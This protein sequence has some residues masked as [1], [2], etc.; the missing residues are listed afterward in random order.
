MPAIET[1]GLTKRFGA[2]VLAVDDLDLTVEE[3]E[4][5]GFLGPNGAG[6]STTINVL[7]DFVRPTAG[8]ARVL[9]LDA[10]A[11]AAAIRE[12]IGV[13]PEGGE[14]YDRLTG[15]E[16][17]EWIARTN[18][19]QESVDYE[20]T[21][22]RV[23]LTAEEAARPV[24]GYSKGMAQR[25][26]F[27][28]A[29]LGEPDLLLLDEPSSG[30]DPTGMQ[31][32]RTIIREEADRGATVFFSSHILGEVESVCDRLGI[33]NEGRL[34]TTGTI[35]ALRDELDLDASVSIEVDA[36]PDGLAADIESNEG[37]HAVE[38]DGTTLTISVANPT[39]KIDAIR[40]VDER[41]TVLDVR[42]TDTSL[43]Q[44]FNTYTGNGEGEPEPS[45]AGFAGDE[46]AETAAEV[47]R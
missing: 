40:R 11:D 43:E 25:L 24:G 19:L 9:G 16:H 38:T 31:E 47:G 20:A 5:F 34:V 12:R 13:L 15:R 30:L 10:Q 23:G 8:S 36:V 37:V 21:L 14:L 41:A 46:T 32:M 22:D 29:I 42:S 35:D 18:D 17:L 27:G 1:D 26:A 44:L 33:M 6:K 3:G 7:L 45:A 28:M 4:V 39:R 2:D